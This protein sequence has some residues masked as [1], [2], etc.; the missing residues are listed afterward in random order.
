MIERLVAARLVTS[1]EASSSSRTRRSPAPGRGCGPGWTTTPTGL[2]IRRHLS[3]AADAWDAMDRPD[4]ETYRGARLARAL[5]WRDRGRPDLTPVEDAFLDAAA[6]ARDG[7]ATADGTREPPPPRPSRGGR[8]AAAARRRRRRPRRPPGK[9]GRRRRDSPPT[10]AASA[11]RP[12]RHR[13]WTGP[14][15]WPCRACAWTT[16]RDARQPPRDAQP[17]APQLIGVIRRPAIDP[18]RL[19]SRSARTGGRSIVLDGPGSVSTTRRRAP[20]HGSRRTWWRPD[21]PVVSRSRPDGAQVA[22]AYRIGL[23]AGGPYADPR[24][25]RAP[26]MPLDAT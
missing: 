11:P 16:E 7:R 2:R 3:V 4:S 24:H 9:P 10:P 5:D 25:P 1:D 26:T 19:I 17:H 13:S 15:C 8:R 14:R 12:R 21:T 18:P 20:R 6:H 22:L 23:D